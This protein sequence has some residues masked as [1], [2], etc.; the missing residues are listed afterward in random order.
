MGHIT[1]E[2]ADLGFA[3]SAEARAAYLGKRR[4]RWRWR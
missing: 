4:P 3:D 2:I 1:V